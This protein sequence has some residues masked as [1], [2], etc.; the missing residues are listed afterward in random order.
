MIQPGSAAES[1]NRTQQLGDIHIAMRGGLLSV[2]TRNA[3]LDEVMRRIG[4]QA[5]FTVVLAD[6]FIDPPLISVSLQGVSV[7]EVVQRLVNDENRIVLYRSEGEQGN[8]QK[9]IYQVWLLGTSGATNNFEINQDNGITGAGEEAVKSHKLTKLTRMLQPDQEVSTRARA[10]IALGAS[11]NEQAVLALEP[12]LL[13]RELA[14]RLQAIKA[15]GRIGGEQATTLVGN[16]FLQENTEQI[17]RVVAAQ[18][19][20]KLDNEIARNYLS[21]GAYDENDQVRRAATTAPSNSIR[22]PT[23][24][25]QVGGIA[26]Q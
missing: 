18:V 25:S 17:E 16:V 2:E 7:A 13:D 11:K 22:Q 26:A 9:V 23:K 21:A 1:T 12:A 5:D 4:E 3:P 15:L 10:A 6:D 24:T 8:E 20:W 14:V 19:L